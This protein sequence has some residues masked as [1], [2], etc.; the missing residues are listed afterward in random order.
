MK[1]LV[2]NSKKE[3]NSLLVT[4]RRGVTSIN[5]LEIGKTKPEIIVTEQGVSYVDYNSNVRNLYAPFV[6]KLLGVLL[7]VISLNSCFASQLP[8]DIDM[9]IVRSCN[10]YEITYWINN[11][12]TNVG[13]IKNTE[14]WNCEIGDTLKLRY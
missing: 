4:N 8:Q 7:L 11:D 14:K 12:S 13:I 3:L 6:V 5:K 10:E 1:T 9:K 2:L